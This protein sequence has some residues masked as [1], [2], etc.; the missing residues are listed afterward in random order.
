MIMQSFYCRSSAVG[1]ECL[2]VC[3][4]GCMVGVQTDCDDVDKSA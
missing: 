1:A 4:G 2:Q 3:T